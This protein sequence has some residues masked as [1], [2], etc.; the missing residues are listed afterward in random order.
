MFIYVFNYSVFILYL[1]ATHTLQNSLLFRI[2]SDMWLLVD[3]ALFNNNNSLD[4]H[5]IPSS[6]NHLCCWNFTIS[7]MILWS[8]QYFSLFNSKFCKNNPW[9]WIVSCNIVVKGLN[10][11]CGRVMFSVVTDNCGNVRPLWPQLR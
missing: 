9:G 4:I 6:E 3:L 8:K 10:C 2:L 7:I 11:G 1:I 5:W